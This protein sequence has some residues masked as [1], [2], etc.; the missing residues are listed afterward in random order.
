[1]PQA[2]SCNPCT[3]QINSKPKSLVTPESTKVVP[4]SKSTDSDAAVPDKWD[5]VYWQLK[6]KVIKKLSRSYQGSYQGTMYNKIF[7]IS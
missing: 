2:T 5:Q 3:A 7:K 1:M 6:N 4:V